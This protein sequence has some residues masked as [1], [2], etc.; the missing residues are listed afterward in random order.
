MVTLNKIVMLKRVKPMIRLKFTIKNWWGPD[1][2]KKGSEAM[3]FMKWLLPPVTMRFRVQCTTFSAQL[4]GRKSFILIFEYY[5]CIMCILTFSS[6]IWVKKCTWYM[7]K[8]SLPMTF[9]AMTS[10]LSPESFTHFQICFPMI[11]MHIVFFYLTSYLVK[12]GFKNSNNNIYKERKLVLKQTAQT[13]LPRVQEPLSHCDITRP[14]T[15]KLVLQ[16][17]Q[18]DHAL[19]A[20]TYCEYFSKWNCMLCLHCL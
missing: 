20:F 4:S 5:P 2:F 12:F 17:K 7:A 18:K 3:L 15:E 9:V 10:C 8:Y 13:Q 1:G 11:N 16:V 14:T 6:Q 19:H